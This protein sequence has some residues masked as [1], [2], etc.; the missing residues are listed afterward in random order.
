MLNSSRRGSKRSRRGNG[1]GRGRGK[2]P[3]KPKVRGRGRGRGRSR[4]RGRLRFKRKKHSTSGPNKRRKVETNNKVRSV[5][6]HENSPSNF[7][8]FSST[9]SN[10]S[11]GLLHRMTGFHLTIFLKIFK[12]FDFFC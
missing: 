6:P 4:G 12:F 8:N 11:K 9:P 3:S 10:Q 5:K 7:S 2:A 1:R